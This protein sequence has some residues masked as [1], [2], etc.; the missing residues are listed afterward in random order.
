MR[1]NNS[2]ARNAGAGEEAP[3][4]KRMFPFR[5]KRRVKSWLSSSPCSSKSSPSK[6]N[7]F[8][9]I[10]FDFHIISLIFTIV[11]TYQL[12]NLIT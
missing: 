1:W 7:T 12:I 10:C 9:P 6:K 2:T 5:E 3:K 4:K 8:L 11:Y